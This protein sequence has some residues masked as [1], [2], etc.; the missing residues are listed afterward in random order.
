MLLVMH[1]MLFSKAGNVETSTFYT[2]PIIFYTRIYVKLQHNKITDIS[3]F[4]TSDIKQAVKYKSKHKKSEILNSS[5][6]KLQLE[7]ENKH[8]NIP[9]K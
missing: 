6:Y 7:K 2:F 1:R 8:K 5:L 4:P 9:N 3:P